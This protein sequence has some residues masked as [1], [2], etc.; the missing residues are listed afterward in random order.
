MNTSSPRLVFIERF[1]LVVALY[2]PVRAQ[3]LIRSDLRRTTIVRHP[4]GMKVFRR[5]LAVE[6][7]CHL[8]CLLIVGMGQ[9]RLNIDSQNRDSVLTEDYCSTHA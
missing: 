6:P 4:T 3:P 8:R 9:Y 5:F 2:T 1:D 7:D